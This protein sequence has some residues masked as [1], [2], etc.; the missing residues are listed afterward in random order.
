MTIG[1]SA[2]WIGEWTKAI[3]WLERLEMLS[4][5]SFQPSEVD[6]HVG[7]AHVFS[8]VE[9][10]A[11]AQKNDSQGLRKHARQ[12]EDR[13]GRLARDQKLDFRGYFWLAYVQDELGHCYEAVRSSRAALA[14]RPGYAPSKYNAAVSL[15][16]LGQYRHALRMIESISSQDEAAKAVLDAA[17]K[18][19]EL[20]TAVKDPVWQQR[21]RHAVR[22]GRVLGGSA[23]GASGAS[24][25]SGA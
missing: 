15:A 9:R 20:W 12:A 25:A 2:F 19:N 1:R 17:E 11:D 13:L 24:G 5:R 7:M 23:I 14:R 10:A 18:D 16:K 6:Y 22:R 8:L 21:M 4:Q 3:H